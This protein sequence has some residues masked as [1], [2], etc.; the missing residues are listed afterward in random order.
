MAETDY[1]KAGIFLNNIYNM[2]LDDVQKKGTFDEMVKKDEE[3]FRNLPSTVQA[4]TFEYYKMLK[5]HDKGYKLNKEEISRFWELADVMEKYDISPI[6][7]GGGPIE[8][9]IP[10]EDE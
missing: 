5:A 10:T 2:L 7:I 8:K 4:D 9:M 1:E 3:R 6:C